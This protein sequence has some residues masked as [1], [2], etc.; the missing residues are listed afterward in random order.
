[1]R[2]PRAPCAAA[3]ALVASLACARSANLPD[4][5]P[6]PPASVVVDSA[7]L[8]AAETVSAAGGRDSLLVSEDE[9]QGWRYY[10]IYCARCHGQ[11]ALGSANAADLRH[12]VSEDGGIGRD[13]FVVI[14]RD[15][16]KDNPE[17]KGFAD[18]LEEERI[19]QI[20]QYVMARSERR[21]AMG[22]PHRRQ[23]PP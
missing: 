11:D 14:V 6:A 16:S 22:R 1:M 4:P 10:H 20:Y 5:P 12:S 17:M 9:Y 18:L 3:V 19:G 2:S 7:K 8:S 21:L 15:G 23:T 13:S